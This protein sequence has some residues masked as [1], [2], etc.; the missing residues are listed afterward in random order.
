[1]RKIMETA[2]I[3]IMLLLV[4][5]VLANIILTINLIKKQD[6]GSGDERLLDEIDRLISQ[7]SDL[8]RELNSVVNASMTAF[9]G[10]LSQNQ[11][12]MNENTISQLKQLEERFKTLETTNE[13]KL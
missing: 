10:V 9:S 12:A 3:V 7:Q 2:T 4:A 1:M 6:G 5:A 11:T 13:Q 8:R